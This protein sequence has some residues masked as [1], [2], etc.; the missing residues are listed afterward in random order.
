[1]KWCPF[2]KITPTPKQLAFLALD[3]Q[4]AFYGGAAGGGK[5]IA[6]LAAALQYTDNPGYAAILFRR[7]FTDL[8][9]PGALIPRAEEWLHDSGA[10]W[11]D[12]DKTWH[13]PSG[14]TLSF[15]YLE[16]SNDK[17]RYQSSEFQY[18]G[19]DELTQFKEE[20]YRYLFSRLRRLK[21]AT[22]PLRVRAASNPGG[23]GHEWVKIRFVDAGSDGERPF[24]TAKLTDNPHLDRDMYEQSLMNLDP[25]TRAH[26]LDGDWSART[27]GGKFKREWFELVDSIPDG[28]RWVRY[29]DMAG[30]LKKSSSSD[31]DWT[32]GVLVG[33][34][35]SGLYYIGDVR[36]LRAT[37]QVIEST[38]KQTAQ[39]DGKST[40]VYMEQEPGA[41]G[42]HLVDYYSRK[43]LQ[44][45]AFYGV[46]PTGDKVTRSNPVSSQAEAGHVK[47]V[48]GNWVLNFLDELEGFPGVAHDDQV[49]ALDGAMEALMSARDEVR[50]RWL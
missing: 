28:C 18:I 30:A 39:I 23:L 34:S 19:F 11:K 15:G 49:D 4:E 7:T 24:I 47:I 1:M 6:L 37:P 33:R 44:G 43:V 48:H 16:S 8:A 41:S 25:I 45:Y 26:L 5:S 3:C 17:Y 2:I 21:S 29:W 31:P 42:I 20:D 32:V 38:I 46:R 35:P 40:T 14:A 9:L 22:V 10:R 50:I 12:I 27:S 36:R 13:F